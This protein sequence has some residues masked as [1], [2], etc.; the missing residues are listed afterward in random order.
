MKQ[1]MLISI[2]LLKDS[3]N[4]FVG[5]HKTSCEV[6]LWPSTSCKT[7][8]IF[9]SVT[10]GVLRHAFCMCVYACAC[11]CMRL[12][13]VFGFFLRSI[14]IKPCSLGTIKLGQSAQKLIAAANGGDLESNQKLN[15]V[16]LIFYHCKILRWIACFTQE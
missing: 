11:V 10:F 7:D 14:L 3:K 4:V 13:E 9:L 16:H 15:Q 1:R 8:E 6:I 5:A 2:L 12:F